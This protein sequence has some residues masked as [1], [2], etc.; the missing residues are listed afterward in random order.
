MT[1]KEVQELITPAVD[2]CLLETDRGPFFAHLELCTPCRRDFEVERRTKALVQHRTCMVATP[3]EVAQA[4][5]AIVLREEGAG[6]DASAIWWQRFIPRPSL[7]PVI[8]LG[9]ALL[10]LI[11]LWPSPDEPVPNVLQA[12]L[13]GPDIVRQSFANFE[14][15]LSGAIRPQLETSEPER[16]R[17]FFSGRTTF[18]VLVPL[19]RHCTL[20]GAVYGDYGGAPLAHTVYRH[21][22]QLLYV[23]QACWET[24]QSG[25]PLVL[26]PQV[27]EE[28]ETRGIYTETRADG[29][30]IVVW[31]TG[32]TLCTAVAQMNRD[33]L[34]ACLDVNGHIWRESSLKPQ[35]VVRLPPLTNANDLFMLHQGVAARHLFLSLLGPFPTSWNL[36]PTHPLP[37]LSPRL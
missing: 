15:L 4:V 19:T 17:N 27:R 6:V 29:L 2:Q 30:T 12:S 1:C 22:G 9:V 26:P 11:V 5:R 25:S 32:P 14:H 24:V 37:R 31:A 8:A 7:G 18:P 28:M 23:Y 36:N 13:V 21:D 34:L 33:G 10:A 35:A 20:V 16:V 3:P